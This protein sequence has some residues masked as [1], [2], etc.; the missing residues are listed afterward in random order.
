M[1]RNGSGV[2]SR[3]AGTA[4]V[5][6]Q[7]I[8]SAKY[9]TLMADIETDLNTARPI[10][11]GGTGSTSAAGALTALGAAS[12]SSLTALDVR[13]TAIDGNSG[14]LTMKNAGGS[15]VG[16]VVTVGAIGGTPTDAM[17]IRGDAGIVLGTLGNAAVFVD[18]SNNVSVGA[19]SPA[20]SKL[21]VTYLQTGT[22]NDGFVVN[23]N[24]GTI[25]DAGGFAFWRTGDERAA[26]RAHY[27][28]GL[29]I[30]VK[31]TTGAL[32]ERFR[33]SV[34]GALGIGGPTYGNA[35]DSLLSGGGAAAPTW[36]RPAGVAAAWVN[37][38]GTPASP[39]IRSSSNVSSITK[40]A[41]GD[42]SVTLTTAMANTNYAVLGT[43]A[44]SSSAN[45]ANPGAY[46]LDVV[47]T[48]TTVF[49]I[50]TGY[51][52]AGTSNMDVVCAAVYGS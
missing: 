17:R 45:Q 21:S 39:T 23:N 9:N 14:G 27:F 1:P 6:G 3:P 13:V 47:N 16:Y 8:E 30:L 44:V 10:V 31:K 50:V 41:T 48:S 4:A 34:D 29:S 35:G 51:G 2:Y 46:G 36:G 18:T 38:N 20:L 32:L 5:S 25:N 26:I 11:A 22:T 7:T 33:I 24:N 37:F 49:R 52:A 40:N 15:V 28:N 12:A 19:V 43:C 42:Y